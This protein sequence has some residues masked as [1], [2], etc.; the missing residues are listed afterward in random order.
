MDPP[1]LSHTD[2]AICH[3]GLSYKHTPIEQR[4]RA[5]LSEAELIQG[6]QRLVA[7]P[8][9]TEAMIL[10]TCHRFE[11]WVVLA[12]PL[13]QRSTTLATLRL[14]LFGRQGDP[15]APG[16]SWVDMD[17]VA[18]LMSVVASLDSMVLGETQITHQFKQA[19]RRAEHAGSMGRVLT[20]LAAVALHVAK[21]VRRE[22]SLGYG[23]TSLAH[24]AVRLADRVYAKLSHCHVVILGAGQMAALCAA[25]AAGGQVKQL[26]ILNRSA[27]R[28]QDLAQQYGQA[29]GGELE[30]IPELLTKADMILSCASTPEYLLTRAQLEP[31][32]KTRRKLG[33][34]YLL[35]C[36]LAMPRSIDPALAEL[37]E[38]YLFDID[39][40]THATTHNRQR[41][42]E[43]AATARGSIQAAATDFMAWLHRHSQDHP[44]GEL[45][46][47]LHHLLTTEM[48]RTLAKSCFGDE[49]T[50]HLQ[51]L[52]QSMG[53]K[54][55]AAIAQCLSS[56]L[57]APQIQ[58][59]ELST[60]LSQ[61][62]ATQRPRRLSHQHPSRQP[63]RSSHFPSA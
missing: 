25:Y 58:L 4:E 54:I 18:H 19:M 12:Q 6:L 51:Q 5:Y 55:I 49:H 61:A 63:P 20:R 23:V 17:A 56:D 27:R 42:E 45:H 28:A 16:Q 47:S 35:I 39:D 9:F 3:W 30:Q 38:I 22:T 26:S 7:R 11:V 44:L 41:K 34:P 32:M 57:S 15:A 1:V 21:K 43:A 46:T 53:Q 10:Q 31:L 14:T 2:P 60:Q 48:R 50:P 37:D 29:Q 36:D 24:A 59:S 33:K 62:T 8:E 40:L 52:T 13:T